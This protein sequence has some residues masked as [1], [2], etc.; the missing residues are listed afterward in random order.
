MVKP[1]RGRPVFHSGFR[2]VFLLVEMHIFSR[3][4]QRAV[5]FLFFLELRGAG[6]AAYFD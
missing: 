3:G 5:F 1:L 4:V 2:F 6:S